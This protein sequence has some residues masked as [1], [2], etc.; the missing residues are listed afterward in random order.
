VFLKSLVKNKK[1]VQ[2]KECFMFTIIELQYLSA[3]VKLIEIQHRT[4]LERVHTT[5]LAKELG[6]KKDYTQQLCT[7]LSKAGIIKTTRGIKG[8]LSIIDEE[9]C[10]GDVIIALRKV[11]RPR[12]SK[13]IAAQVNILLKMLE[14]D[15]DKSMS[16]ISLVK[17]AHVFDGKHVPR[18][19]E[20][21]VTAHRPN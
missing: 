6:L 10:I 8:G 5:M 4:K 1:P 16:G 14:Q 2:R 13:G 3:V 17:L 12:K 21:T 11:K 9:M 20:F 18:Y 15:I 19:V 7:T